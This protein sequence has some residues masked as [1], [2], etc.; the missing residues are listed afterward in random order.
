MQSMVDNCNEKVEAHEQK[1]INRQR[2][3]KVQVVISGGNFSHYWCDVTPYYIICQ[4]QMLG[5]ST[6]PW[7]SS[8]G[9]WLSWNKS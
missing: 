7:W 1:M 6:M 5:I 8:P 3:D 9:Y 2:E 4:Q